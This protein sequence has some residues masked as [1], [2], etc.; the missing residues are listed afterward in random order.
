MPRD[1][2]RLN[3][4]STEGPAR[5]PAAQLLAERTA[6]ALM[7][8][9]SRQFFAVVWGPI[10]GSAVCRRFPAIVPSNEFLIAETCMSLTPWD[11]PG[12]RC[13]PKQPAQ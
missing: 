13:Q 2:A 1:L 8:V 10:V 5:P 12:D 4:V 11:R 7:V 3:G 9:N 6:S